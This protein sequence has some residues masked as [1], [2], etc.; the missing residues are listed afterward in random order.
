[1]Q[2]TN[3]KDDMEDLGKS[4]LSS[5]FLFNRFF[6]EL[7]TQREFL[8]SKP[9]SNESHFITV[10]RELT[11]VFNLQT[12]RLMINVPPG[13]GKAIDSNTEMLTKTGWKLAREITIHD[14]LLGSNGWVNVMGVFPQGILKAK[15]VIFNDG[16]HLICNKEHLWGV[17]D[18][19]TAKLKV[20]T[21]DE[22]SETLHESD[23]RKH[24]RIPLVNGDYGHI[25][26]EIDPYLWGC[27][28]GDGHSR[29][30]KITTMDD[31]IIQAFEDKG[32]ILK[33]N[34]GYSNG[35]ASTY[36][37]IHP[38][39][40]AH[41]AKKLRKEN[42]MLN[43]HFPKTAYFWKKE[44]RLSLL[45]G[46][47]D[48]D[49]TCGK[50][51]RPSFC[52]KNI[53]LIEGFEFLVA[54]L[55]GKSIRSPKN[56]S[57]NVK[58]RLPIGMQL[59]RLKRKQERVSIDNHSIPTRL[60]KCINEDKERDMVCFMVDSDDHLFAAGRDLI[61]THNSVMCQHF[62]AFCLAWYPDCRFLYISHSFELAAS[63]THTIKKIMMLPEYRD[64]FNV[65]IRKDQSAKDFF[66]TTEGGAV[67][68]F[69]AKG[70]VTGRD[71]GLPGLDRFSG[72]LLI[73][74][75]HKPDEVHSDTIREKVHKNYFETI[76]PRL[77]GINVP[78]VFIGQRLHE[79][80]L[81]AHLL[82][83]ADGQTWKTVIIKALD[84]HNNARYPEVMPAEKLL[85]MKEKQPYVF[86]GQ[87]M[88]E[89]V[90]AGGALFKEEW[91]DTLEKEPEILSTFITMDSSET[92]KTYN[93]A[94]AISFWGLHKLKHG[95]IDLDLYGLHWLNC[96]E[97][98]VEPKDLEEL[99]M[100]FY[101]SCLR[102]DK[103]PS[104]IAIEKKSS[105]TTLLSVLKR[106]QGLNL[107]DI[108]R[109]AVS[110]SKTD[111]FLT[112]QP[113][114]ASRQ[115]TLPMYGKH[116]QL[117]IK[118]MTK[119][120]ANNT[121]ARDDIADTC[122]DSVEIALIRRMIIKQVENKPSDSRTAQRI[123]SR[124]NQVQKLREQAYGNGKN[125]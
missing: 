30:A 114:I 23:D 19:Y 54:S 63:H 94:T 22:L 18:R 88:Q 26:P 9:T 118:H 119:I 101:A 62:I 78:V 32:Y 120:T 44:D 87:Y 79:D 117:C 55:G 49:G 57:Y 2:A 56:G 64:L 8:I 3:I 81:P 27:W 110:G 82:A 4:L 112:I 17:Y 29:S 11:Q 69:G 124:F 16:S 116:N 83:G 109:S 38:T 106:R 92:E 53:S 98:W 50:E 51:G 90:P 10:A 40:Y 7:R 47:L 59:F 15:K 67:A 73:D 102:H 103:K 89:P 66:E 5:F 105:G 80:D 115:I 104:A 12:K 123:M 52:N 35:K 108:E 99:F 111:R 58:F 61:L 14:Q 60:I 6:Y 31:E 71:A 100:D 43:K 33:K 125:R 24:W 46:L 97:A 93:D 42:Q 39:I 96:I 65:H 77:R 34:I 68:A 113:Y 72:C 70:S 91:F 36:S 45:Q 48:T 95:E 75:I 74:D 1:M 85:I 107:I 13:W 41:F 84:P 20:R 121:H 122:S 76:E 37:I 28:L 86:S 21:T 25:D